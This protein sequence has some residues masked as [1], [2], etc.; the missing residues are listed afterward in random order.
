MGQEFNIFVTAASRRVAMIRGFKSALDKL[1]T[2]GRVIVSDTDRM[3]TGLRFC[4]R[5]HIVPLSSSNDYIPQL[6]EICEKERIKLLAPTIDE[7]LEIF[8]QHKKDFEAVGVTALVSDKEVGKVCRDKYL[9]Y[10]FFKKNGFPFAETFLPSQIDYSV[11][12]YPM[13]IKPRIGRGSVGAHPIKNEKEL[14]FFIDYVDDPVIQRFLTGDEYTVDVLASLD[15]RILSVVPRERLVI[16]AG[17]CDRGRTRKM[18]KLI[19]LSKSICEKL[20]VIGPVNLQ[21]MVRNGEIHFFEVNPRFSG[22]IQLTV[23]SG[24]DFFTMIVKEALGQTV[25][26]V[27]GEFKDNFMM[28]SYEE[29]IFESMNG[30]KS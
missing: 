25:E 6:L 18:P 19:D 5:F 13:F 27:I 17:V 29:S 30:A 16:R 4:D 2:P 15:G 9:T 24:A 10:K 14:R 1:G 28:L 23:A 26:P 11:V 21:C 3:S 7:E 8:G 22:A 12:K 20:G